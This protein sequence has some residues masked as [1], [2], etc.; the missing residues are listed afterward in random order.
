MLRTSIFLET[1]RVVCTDLAEV[2]RIGN[3]QSIHPLFSIDFQIV[4][5]VERLT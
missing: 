5:V 4:D 1:T 3:E 2:C